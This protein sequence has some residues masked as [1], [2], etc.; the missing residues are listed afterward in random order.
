[1]EGG[2]AVMLVYRVLGMLR[3]VWL[4][5]AVDF[6]LLSSSSNTLLD[7]ESS[8]SRSVYCPLFFVEDAGRWLS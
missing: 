1:M 5:D 2:R 4:L 6:I 8:L 7:V 3:V